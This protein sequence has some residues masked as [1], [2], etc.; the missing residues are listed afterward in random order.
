MT[1]AHASHWLTTAVYM[2]PIVAFLVW[3]V[4]VT[5]RDRVRGRDG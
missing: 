4:F 2:L 3:L 1:P 5:V